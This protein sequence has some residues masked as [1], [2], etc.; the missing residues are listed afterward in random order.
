[1]E[2]HRKYS[3]GGFTLIELLIVIAII[4]ILIAIALPNF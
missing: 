1:M 2:I 4:L 3:P